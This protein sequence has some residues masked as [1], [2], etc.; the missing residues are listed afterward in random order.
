[1]EELRKVEYKVKD[2]TQE[3]WEDVVWSNIEK[4]MVIR[5]FEVDGTP[6][7]IY[8]NEEKLPVYEATAAADSYTNDTG[9]WTINT[10]P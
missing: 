8:Y 5:M 9:V 2:G 1:M 7:P 3:S 6:I 4:G 10:K